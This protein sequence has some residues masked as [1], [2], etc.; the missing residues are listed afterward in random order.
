MTTQVVGLGISEPSTCDPTWIGSGEVNR[1][2]SHLVNDREG[3]AF[4][5]TNKGLGRTATKKNLK[6]TNCFFFRQ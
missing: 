3:M 5:K 1:P 2:G 6:L 4:P